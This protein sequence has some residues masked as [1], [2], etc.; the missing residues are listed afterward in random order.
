MRYV[1]NTTMGCKGNSHRRRPARNFFLAAVV[2]Q[3]MCVSW[4]SARAQQRVIP[5]EKGVTA[6]P[7]VVSFTELAQREAA[8][9]HL[10]MATVI[11]A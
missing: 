5:A 9:T 8:A 7:V 6:A 10:T 3:L 4:T 2:C 11:R 1:N